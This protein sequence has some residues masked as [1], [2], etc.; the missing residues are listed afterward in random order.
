MTDRILIQELTVAATI[1]VP[2]LERCTPQRLA[3]DVV[4][5]GDFRGLADDIDGTTDYA[6]VAEWLRLECERRPCR[7]I[8]SLADHLATGLL[9]SFVQVRAV[10]LEIRK[11]ILPATRHVAV[12]VRRERAV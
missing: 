10:E 7:L 6:A 11:F 8:E 4:L 5:E 12:R 1:G 3:I 9:A 2:D